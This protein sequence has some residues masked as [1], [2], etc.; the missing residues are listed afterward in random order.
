MCRL[1]Q[2][3]RVTLMNKI[4]VAPLSCSL[5]SIL[6]SGS[7]VISP[8]GRSDYDT[9]ENPLAAHYPSYEIQEGFRSPL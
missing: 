8:K 2:D 5:Q 6:R 9:V 3:G 1:M 4:A 7:E